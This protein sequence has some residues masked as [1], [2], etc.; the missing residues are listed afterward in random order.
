MVKPPRV[1]RQHLPGTTKCRR[2]SGVPR[3]PASC[4]GEDTTR[5][6][7]AFLPRRG[8]SVA[9]EEL[10][11]TSTPLCGLESRD[12]FRLA[13]PPLPLTISPDITHY[14]TGQ[15]SHPRKSTRTSPNSHNAKARVGS[16]EEI[17]RGDSPRRETVPYKE[18]I[19][20]PSALMPTYTIQRER[21]DTLQKTAIA[22][23]F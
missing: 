20:S 8:F 11:A 2:H 3:H 19:T 13:F 9:Q 1:A 23:T 17:E 10:R 14:E 4:T 21:T 12:V 16:Y 18:S 5:I 6:T 22:L 15:N 7:R